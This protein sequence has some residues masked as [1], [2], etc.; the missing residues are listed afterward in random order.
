VID[1]S[2]IPELVTRAG[3]TGP[4]VALTPL[5]LG[6]GPT[7]GGIKQA[8]GVFVVPAGDTFDLRVKATLATPAR[9]SATLK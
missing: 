7:D 5:S 8:F 2:V 6:Y 9:I 3:G 1:E 4:E